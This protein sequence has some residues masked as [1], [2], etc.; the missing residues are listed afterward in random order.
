MPVLEIRTGLI[1]LLKGTKDLKTSP[2]C[3]M[4]TSIGVSA[5]PNHIQ[6][7][8]EV[9]QTVKVSTRNVVNSWTCGEKLPQPD[10]QSCL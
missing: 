3:L 10:F 1:A 8:L 9:T 7:K 2:S 4:K 5:D 6:T